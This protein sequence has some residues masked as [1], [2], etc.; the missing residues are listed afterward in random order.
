MVG[1]KSGWSLKF[2]KINVFTDIGFLFFTL[3]ICSI[4]KRGNMLRSDCEVSSGFQ[5]SECSSSVEGRNSKITGEFEMV[6][7]FTF[8]DIPL[9]IFL[10]AEVPYVWWLIPFRVMFLL[11]AFFVLCNIFPF[12]FNVSIL[13]LFLLSLYTFFVNTS[14]YMFT[15]SAIGVCDI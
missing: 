10:V 12:S 13:S 9:K 4:L 11:S 14:L 7:H 2:C 5:K 15:A 1:K 3:L 6:G 8:K